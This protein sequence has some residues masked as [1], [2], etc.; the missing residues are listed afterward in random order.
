MDRRQFALSI[1]ATFAS[2]AVAQEISKSLKVA[3]IGHTGRGDYGHGLDKVWQRNGRTSIVAVA[4]ANEAGL[5]NAARRLQLDSTASFRDYRQMLT[6]VRPDMVA[7]CPRHV[8]QHHGMI[9]AAIESGAKGIYV[10]KPFLRTPAECDHVLAAAEKNGTRIA[11]AHRNRYHPVMQIV[12]DLIKD[13]RIGR[14]LEIRGRGKGDRR[15]GG[16]DLWVLG[17]HVLNMVNFLAGN[18]ISCSAE[19]L[20]D[21]RRVKPS[22]VRKGAEGLGP[23]AGNEL[24]ARFML[25]SGITVYFDSIANDQTESHGF[26]LQLIGSKGIISMRTDRDPLAHLIPGNPFEPTDKPRPWLPISTGGVD[27]AEPEP[28]LID[29]IF[30][31]DTA[32]ADLITAIDEDRQPWCSAA[33]GA[34]TVEMICGVFQSHREGKTVPFPLQQREHPLA[35]WK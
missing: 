16:E 4:D 5:A 34:L 18:P 19:M 15:G 35:D 32:V 25:D 11:I 29:H 20:Q 28:K 26:G 13:G 14:L 21:G 8:D 23:L 17:S 33:E 1:L 6:K 30:H 2:Q 24:H 10:E 9:M 22:D 12:A 3:V 31:H 7:V 27:V